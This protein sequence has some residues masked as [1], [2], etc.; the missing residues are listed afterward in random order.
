MK[1]LQNIRRLLW[2]VWNVFFPSPEWLEEARLEK[3]VARSEWEDEQRKG[4]E[5]KPQ[6]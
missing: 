6:P 5:Q 2:D 3:E 1:F 4:E